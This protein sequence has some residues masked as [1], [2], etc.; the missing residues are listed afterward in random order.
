MP[1]F[2]ARSNRIKTIHDIIDNYHNDDD[3]NSGSANA[4]YNHSIRMTHQPSNNALQQQQ[5]QPSFPFR[6]CVIPSLSNASTKAKEL[7]HRVV[8]EFLPIITRRQYNILSISEMC[9]CN[10]GLDFD[11]NESEPNNN[12]TN[13]R[14]HKRSNKRKRKLMGS[15]VWGYNQITTTTRSRSRFNLQHTKS[16]TIHIRLRKPNNHQQFLSYEDVA[17]TLAH[18][19]AHC[20][21]APHDA[22]FYKVM[23]GILEEHAQQQITRMHPR[24]NVPTQ[25]QQQTVGHKLG[26]DPTFT[27]WMTPKEAAVAAAECRRRQHILRHRGDFG[28]CQTIQMDD[29]EDDD[30]NDGRDHDENN[31]K[32]KKNQN[33]HHKSIQPPKKPRQRRNYK[34]E[35]TKPLKNIIPEVVD[36]TTNNTNDNNVVTEQRNDWSCQWC[37]YRNRAM[38]LAC[39]ICEI[40]RNAFQ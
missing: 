25:Q 33:N 35:T 7:L 37:T 4:S 13:S 29:D 8:Q 16:H 5:Q 3:D 31:N 26:G 2:D 14:Q 18:E 22:Q 20:E 40:E 24:A 6:V 30:N 15:N 21:R 19:L 9:C 27:C 12:S 28:C 11:D 17:G 23:D 34:N 36:L 39:D 32:N 38:A 10:D 1:V